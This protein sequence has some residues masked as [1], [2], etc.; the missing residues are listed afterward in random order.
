MKEEITTGD[1]SVTVACFM[2]VSVL[3]IILMYGWAFSLLW[4]WYMVV[5]FNLPPINAFIGAGL[6]MLLKFRIVG[7]TLSIRVKKHLSEEE[8]KEAKEKIIY[9][10]FKPF[11]MI[12]MGYSFAYAGGLV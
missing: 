7:Q 9:M 12:A 10:L 6:M 8:K 3:G 11:F 5:L 4:G 1:L 2:L